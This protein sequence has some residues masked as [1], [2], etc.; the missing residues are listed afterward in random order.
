MSTPTIPTI[1]IQDF[2]DVKEHE[3]LFFIETRSDTKNM[4]IHL[5][6]RSD[7]YGI[8]I[9]TEGEGTFKVN[10]ESYK[11]QKNSAISV[12]PETIKQWLHRSENLKTITVFFTKDFIAPFLSNPHWLDELS[13]FSNTNAAVFQLNEAEFDLIQNSLEKI[14]TKTESSGSFKKE[15]MVH[16]LQA[17]LLEYFEIYETKDSEPHLYKTPS[18]AQKI[19][20]DFKNLVNKHSLYQRK[21]A[22]YADKLALTTKHLT[23]TIKLETGKTAGE[24]IDEMVLLEA[25]ILLHKPEYTIAQIADILSFAD[26]SAFGKF[27]KN[28]EGQSPKNYREEN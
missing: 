22:F 14:K 24:W 20:S 10:L 2:D 21:L 18:R 15:I 7:Y 11:V 27:F 12:A 26:Q 1:L 25:K 9:V 6:Y 5:P 13:F 17:T 4:P 19:A 28:L 16:L 23:E 3:Q 8:G